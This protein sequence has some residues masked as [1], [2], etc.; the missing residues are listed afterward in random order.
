MQLLRLPIDHPDFRYRASRNPYW[1][2]LREDRLPVYCDGETEAHRGDW[3]ARFA[4]S[5]G[6]SRPLHVEIGC[7]AGHVVLEWATR[8]PRAC[9]IGL[10]WKFKMI[11]KG[12]SFAAKR[13]LSNLLFLRAQ[14]DRLKYIFA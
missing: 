13:G 6:A 10:D 2:K 8:S 3:R 12:A 4:M 7:N 11:H 9:Y 14:A 1:A 5:G